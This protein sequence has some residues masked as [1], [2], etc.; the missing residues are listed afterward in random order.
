MNAVLGSIIEN[1]RSIGITYS[2]TVEIFKGD[3]TN[4]GDA[5]EYSVNDFIASYLTQDYEVKK[6]KIYCL[7]GESQ[8]IDC[9][10]LAPNHPKLITPV[11]DVI[12]A[13]G[14]FCAIEVKPDIRTLSDSSEFYRGLKQMKSIK[15]LERTVDRL[16][17]NSLNKK[18]PLPP[19]FDKIPA[20]L[21]SKECAE[22]PKMI[23]FIQAKVKINELGKE[24][25]PD[26]IFSIEKGVLFYSP[27]FKHTKFY[28]K[29]SPLQKK[30]F[31]EEAFMHIQAEEQHINLLLFLMF[32]LSFDTPH[33]KVSDFF[34][35]KYFNQEGV[36]IS[37]KFYPL[38]KNKIGNIK[39][40]D[41]IKLRKDNFK[42]DEKV[43]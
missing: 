25:L 14:V 21:F 24:E 13:E 35:K 38:D 5:K 43:S 3:R 28:K 37:T 19:Y 12:L 15:N 17:L 8:N 1:L 31:D 23:E 26:L 40:K 18:E 2:P 41:L 20:V 6:G 27:Y 42:N 33:I 30:I 39:P 16:N 7:S 11:R 36:S 9:V 34:I 22:I 32:V 4:T 10:V 29:L